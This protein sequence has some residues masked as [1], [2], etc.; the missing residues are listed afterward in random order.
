MRR[1]FTLIEL[2]VVIVIIALLATVSMYA[3][4]GVQHRARRSAAEAAL[5]QLQS[6]VDSYKSLY[7]KWPIDPPWIPPQCP[8]PVAN[9]YTQ[10]EL[11]IS[12]LRNLKHDWGTGSFHAFSAEAIQ[13]NPAGEEFLADPWGRPIEI[14]VRIRN[15]G[16]RE[17]VTAICAYS[18]GEDGKDQWPHLQAWLAIPGSHWP[19]ADFYQQD[20]RDTL[21]THQN[22]DNIYPP[23]N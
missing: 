13:M 11:N 19:P 10:A 23:A 17:Q 22:I 18:S 6:A 14:K 21:P 9:A 5:V 16:G 15:I 20:L 3:L 12:L 4:A 8:E 2:L 7:G 1:A